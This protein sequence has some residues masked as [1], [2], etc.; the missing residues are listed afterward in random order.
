MKHILAEDVGKFTAEIAHV[1]AS[2]GNGAKKTEAEREISLGEE[3][4][5]RLLRKL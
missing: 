1:V 4:R 5:L 3:K 2:L